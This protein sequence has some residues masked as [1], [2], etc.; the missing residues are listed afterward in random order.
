[1]LTDDVRYRRLFGLEIHLTPVFVISGITIVL[2]VVGTLLFLEAATEIFGNTREW[3]TTRFDWFFML[4]ANLILLFCLYVA[5]SP[6]GRV[7][8]G[9]MD[10]KPQYS[11]TTWFS[12]LFAAG[13]GIGLLF[14]GVAEPVYYY[15]PS[16]CRA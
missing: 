5:V 12:M 11:N 13:V 10:E 2:F 9:G 6:L 4:T 8:L 14:Y 1:M 7:R 16:P 3:L 15:R